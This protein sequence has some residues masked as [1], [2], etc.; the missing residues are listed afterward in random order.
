MQASGF[1]PEVRP[2]KDFEDDYGLKPEG[3]E[4]ESEDDEDYET[5]SE[6]GSEEE[7]EEE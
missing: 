1:T 5:G 7:S 2:L 6:E 4:E 3:E